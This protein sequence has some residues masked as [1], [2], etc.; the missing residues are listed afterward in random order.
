MH[1]CICLYWAVCVC[2]IW[3]DFAKELPWFYFL[4][5]LSIFSYTLSFV[6]SSF[7]L[8]CV[9]CA[10]SKLLC[11][12]SNFIPLT[13]SFTKMFCHLPVHNFSIRNKI[14]ALITARAISKTF[15]GSVV[16]WI[17][18]YSSDSICY[19]TYNVQF[20]GNSIRGSLPQVVQWSLVY[21]SYFICYFT[22]N[23]QFIGNSIRGSL[24]QVSSSKSLDV[25]VVICLIY[26]FIALIEY[27]VVGITSA[28]RK[29]HKKQEVSSL[30]FTDLCDC[31]LPFQFVLILTYKKQ[32]FD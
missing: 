25:Y 9:T 19:F 26:V 4:L 24:P 28:Q 20:L 3:F 17:L 29:N 7:F 11:I 12:Y 15:F 13:V 6:R 32:Y 14:W 18:V 10:I 2:Y 1:I 22:Y 21:S 31:L 5:L 16:Q 27:A 8:L 30:C 23:V